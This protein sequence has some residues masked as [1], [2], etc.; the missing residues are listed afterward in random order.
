MTR[1][2]EVDESDEER[3]EEE[4]EFSML[5]ERGSS[6]AIRPIVPIV[7]FANGRSVETYAM[8]GLRSVIDPMESLWMAASDTWFT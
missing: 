6:G 4:D 8:F 5:A 1:R 3:K 7:M 2:G